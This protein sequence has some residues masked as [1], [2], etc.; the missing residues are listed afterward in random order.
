MFER[1]FLSLAMVVAVPAF[2]QISQSDSVLSPNI[3]N[4]MAIPPPLSGVAF[5]VEVG[6]EMQSNYLR[7]GLIFETAYVDNLYPGTGAPISETTYSILPTITLDQTTA[8]QHRMFNYS[9]GFT[10]Y[11]PSSELNEID[12]SATVSYQIRLTP[13]SSLSANDLFEDSSTAFGQVDS[14]SLGGVSGSPGLFTPGIIPPFARRLTNS[15]IV[16][17]TLQ[18]G[19]DSMI[20]AS[21]VSTILHYP[22]PSEVIGLF[23]SSSRGGTAFYSRRIS[24]TQY[25]G[26]I[27]QYSDMLTYPV[28]GQ[29]ETRSQAPMIF[30]SVYPKRAFSLSLSCG[31][32]YYEATQTS[33]PASASWTPSVS[34]SVGW[35][36]VHT[37]FASSYSQSVTGGGGLVGAYSSKAA[38]ATA[39]WQMSRTMSVGASGSYSIINSATPLFSIGIEN[40]HTVS[41]TATLQRS[42]GQQFGVGLEYDRLNEAYSGIA[43]LATNPNSDRAMITLTWQF[44]RPLGR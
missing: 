44:T 15:G 19:R 6:A 4:S 22:N 40:G 34:A 14:A 5:P 28:V 37:S 42:L 25:F 20:G 16:E 8:R 33:L 30:Y 24:D 18:T 43:V 9:G 17:Y 13:H 29:S 12:E 36:G 27:Y 31:P 1:A 2:A 38:S 7:T 3:G 21:G 39:R 10:F 41:G 23:D 11:D 26:A 32:E 35:Q